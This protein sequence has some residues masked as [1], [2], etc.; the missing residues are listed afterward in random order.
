MRP[1]DT[2]GRGVLASGGAAD[3]GT[4]ERR[5]RPADGAE[6][7]DDG[8]VDCGEVAPFRLA[9]AGEDRKSVV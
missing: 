7:C 6:A 4:P 1:R 8:S 5:R 3:F 2:R 9:R